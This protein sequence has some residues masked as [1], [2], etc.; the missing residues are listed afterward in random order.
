[1]SHLPKLEDRDPKPRGYYLKCIYCWVGFPVFNTAQISLIKTAFITK[2]NLTK[3]SLQPEVADYLTDLLGDSLFH[4]TDYPRYALIHIN[5]YS[6]NWA[7][8]V[9]LKTKKLSF[10]CAVLCAVALS[11]CVSAPNWQHISIKDK[12][13]ASKQLI[14]D[15][16]YCEMVSIGSA[17]MPT[18]ISSGNNVNQTTTFQISGP[19][20]LY[21]GQANS[22]PSGGFGGGFASGLSNSM[23]NFAAMAALAQQT[24]MYNACMNAKGWIDVPKDAVETQAPAPASKDVGNIYADIR[25]YP[26]PKVEWEIDVEEF[27]WFY[28]QYSSGKSYPLLDKIVRAKAKDNPKMNGPQ[29]LN[30]ALKELSSNGYPIKDSSD[31]DLKMARSTYQQ[32]ISGNSNYQALL[33]LFYFIQFKEQGKPDFGPQR[34]TYWAKQSAESGSEMGIISL[35]SNLFMGVGIKQDKVKACLILRRIKNNPTAAELLQKFESN[36][37]D[38]ELSQVRSYAH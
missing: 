37:S 35:S 17:P 2:F 12:P 24:R 15:S 6:Y 38:L 1:M 8:T 4:T 30:L 27:F 32:A 31:P 25:I 9:V 29:I 34:S 36:M 20:G 28:P 10:S 21:T 23:G 13:T 3:P 14:V 16:G 7:R 26:S 33:S 18:V 19:T 11:A 22:Y 5:T